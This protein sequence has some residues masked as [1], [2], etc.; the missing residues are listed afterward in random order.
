MAWLC[1][2]SKLT[3]FLVWVIEIDL[4]SVWKIE[5]DLISVLRSKLAWFLCGWSKLTCF[6]YRDQNWLG[7]CA[8]G[9]NW[10]WCASRKWL[11]LSTE[12]DGLVFYVGDWKWLDFCVRFENDLALVG[13]SKLTWFLCGWSKLTWFQ[14]WRWKLTWFQFRSRNS[15]VF[16][17]RVVKIYLIFVYRPKLTWF[18]CAWSKLAWFQCGWFLRRVR[19][20]LGFSIWIEIHL[21]FR[22]G[23]SV[24]AWF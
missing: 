21:F 23:A 5:I 6:Q 14:G 24:L 10:F 11:V 18:L 9:R 12:I 15:L 1:V 22:V 16:F 2:A 13:V 17:M 20:W 8:G 4:M 3:W 7:I 19:K